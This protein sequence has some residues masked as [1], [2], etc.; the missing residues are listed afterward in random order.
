MKEKKKYIIIQLVL[1]IY[2]V[3]AGLILPSNILLQYTKY[4]NYRHVPWCPAKGFF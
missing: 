1:A 4:W 2:I 3:P